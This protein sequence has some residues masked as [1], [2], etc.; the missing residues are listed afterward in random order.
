MKSYVTI[1]IDKALCHVLACSSDLVALPCLL[2]PVFSTA[3][4][5]SSACFEL[6]SCVRLAPNLT[7]ISMSNFNNC[8]VL[9]KRSLKHTLLRLFHLLC[10]YRD[11]GMINNK[12]SHST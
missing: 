1:Y 2:N 8:S 6:S 7:E 9:G 11:K 12:E 10:L 4:Q 5:D 3:G